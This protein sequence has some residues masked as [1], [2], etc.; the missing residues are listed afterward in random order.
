MKFLAALILSIFVPI[1]NAQ[2]EI[3]DGKTT[4]SLRGIDAVS[5]QVAWASGSGGTVLLTTDGGAT[6]KHCATPTGAEKLDF[7]GVQAFD[8]T[9][10]VIM[11][12]GRGPQSAIYK[13]TDGCATW[14]M[15]FADPDEGGFFDA[16]HKVTSKQMYLMGDQVG[17][18]FSMFYSADQGAT[19]YIADD[20]GLEADK[21]DGGFAASN[22][23]FLS[24][25]S[26]LYFGTG[27]AATPHV[28]NTY[29]KCADGA[30]KDA[31]CPLAWEKHEVPLAAGTAGA[32]VFSLAGRAVGSMSGKITPVIVAVG[33]DY[34]KPDAPDGTAATTRDGVKWTLATIP[35]HGYRS[36]VAFDSATQ[37][38]IAVG[39][40]GSDYS[41]DDGKNW[42]S[43]K[44]S[45]SD[46][47]DAD[48][49]W[50]AISLPFVVGGK[51]KI[52]KL[53]TGVL[54]Q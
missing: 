46:A 11:A 52:G 26:T 30:P 19:W 22:S 7:R 18:K 14:K 20:P 25:G 51:G 39:P 31:S 1:A 21:G 16:L 4:A 36:A 44:P 28:Y 32:G 13:T 17:G 47:P 49:N 50:N 29:A 6:W 35:P 8:A 15:V 41:R 43:L 48:K 38:W 33:G 42:T 3:L 23:G 9:T 5:P 45:A 12:S 10:A 54:A 37:T 34:Q 24:I 27:G 2:F 53:K 40:N